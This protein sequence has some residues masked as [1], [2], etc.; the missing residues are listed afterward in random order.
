MISTASKQFKISSIESRKTTSLEIKDG[1]LMSQLC[2]TTFFFSRCSE[3]YR[4]CCRSAL[5]KT[6]RFTS[7]CACLLQPRLSPYWLHR[8]REFLEPS[9]F[10]SLCWCWIARTRD[11]SEMCGC[12]ALSSLGNL[13]FCR[14]DS[15]QTT[16]SWGKRLGILEILPAFE[17]SSKFLSTSLQLYSL[18]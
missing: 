1:F 7:R 15:S 17:S 9:L 4:G 3:S 10:C 2:E 14:I 8:M 13:E 12:T 18:K 11:G 16:I 6:Y 5:W